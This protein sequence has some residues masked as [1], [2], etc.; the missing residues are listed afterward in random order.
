M[1]EE[2]TANVTGGMKTTMTIQIWAHF[3]WRRNVCSSENS[4]SLDY[5]AICQT[6]RKRSHKVSRSMCTINSV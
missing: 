1:G 4:G 6:H 2:E 5:L 3:F